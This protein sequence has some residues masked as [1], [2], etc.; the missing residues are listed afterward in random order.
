MRAPW[1]LTLLSEAVLSKALSL[2]PSKRL[3]C[4]SRSP[5][6]ELALLHQDCPFP[7]PLAAPRSSPGALC[8][9]EQTRTQQQHLVCP[10][11]SKKWDPKMKIPPHAGSSWC[12][13]LP[14]VLFALP[15]TFLLGLDHHPAPE[16]LPS[17]CTRWALWLIRGFCPR[18]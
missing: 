8:Q 6:W 10:K 15:G 11:H 9:H 12:T 1:T 17:P 14:Q 13:V 16:T 18:V 5:R 7:L 4:L 2:S 3:L